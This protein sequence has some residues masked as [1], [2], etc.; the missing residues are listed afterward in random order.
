MFDDVSYECL[1]CHVT[2]HV[3]YMLPVGWSQG[4]GQD[5]FPLTDTIQCPNCSYPSELTIPYP[6]YVLKQ[7]TG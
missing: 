5:E 7:V 4:Y 2:V 6:C 1:Y 3:P